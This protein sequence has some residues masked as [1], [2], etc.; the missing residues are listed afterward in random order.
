MDAATIQAKINYGLGKAAT[1]MGYT[2]TQY[3]PAS[4]TLA[5]IISGNIIQTLPVSYNAQDRTYSKPNSYGKPL[6]FADCDRTLFQVGDYLQS[7]Q[8]GTFFVAAMQSLLPTLAVQCN[9][10][11]TITRPVS[12]TGQ[13]GVGVYGGANVATDTDIL[14][15]YPC[16]ILQ[17]SKGDKSLV[18][19]PGDV[20]S[21]WW[22]V[23][24][25]VIPGGV[26]F[27]NND[28][29]YDGNGKRY[30][31]SSCELTDLGWRITAT[32]SET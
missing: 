11:I 20:R 25:P 5:P 9:Q 28:I 29:A 13:V 2:S 18:N 16:S 32:E 15:S 7:A 24:L 3:R 31:L 12:T 21:P 14:N 23:L 10:T 30:K 6:W 26:Q 27:Y 19:L 17:G 4:A 1:I 22:F 8:D